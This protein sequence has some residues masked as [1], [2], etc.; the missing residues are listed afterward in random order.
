[1]A[2]V[3]AYLVSHCMGHKYPMNVARAIG[4]A[5]PPTT[6]SPQHWLVQQCRAFPTSESPHYS[7]L[8]GEEMG[9]FTHQGETEAY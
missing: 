3:P 8:S 2:G 1:M 5:W 9:K 6:G 7:C 4:T